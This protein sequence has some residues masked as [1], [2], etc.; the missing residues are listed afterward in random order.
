MPLAEVLP[1]DGQRAAEHR[2]GADEVALV[3][4]HQPEIVPAGAD[5]RM[6]VGRARRGWSRATA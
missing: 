6:I 3:E 2:F 4:Q 1:P 5:V